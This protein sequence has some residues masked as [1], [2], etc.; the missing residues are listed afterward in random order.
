MN[1][2]VP[3]G[4]PTV[5]PWIF[6]RLTEFYLNYA[7]AQYHLGNE[8]QAR[9]YVN[10]IRDRVDMPAI[11]ESGAALLERIQHERQI[12]LAYEGHRFYDVRR[13]KIAP[14]VESLP[15]IGTRVEKTETGEFIYTRFTIMERGW[16][17]N[18][19]YLPI[20]QSEILK[21]NNS[22]IQNPG[23]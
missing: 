20:P 7:E 21:S 9:T 3:V 23:W 1:E 15:L 14:E 16:S 4:D 12:E 10:Y 19:Y 18:Y 11:T 5:T 8:E 13:W 6:F 17:D 2:S 22:L